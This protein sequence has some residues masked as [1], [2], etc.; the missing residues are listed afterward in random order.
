MISS[1]TQKASTRS[2]PSDSPQFI[3]KEPATF[4]A[5]SDKQNSSYLYWANVVNSNAKLMD[6]LEGLNPK[7]MKKM[8]KI[9]PYWWM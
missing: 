8:A 2:N 4:W 1:I 9:R 5:E 3:E 6:E 7:A